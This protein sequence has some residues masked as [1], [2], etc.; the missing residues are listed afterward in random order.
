MVKQTN[1][2]NKDNNNNDDSDRIKGIQ[3]LKKKKQQR[4]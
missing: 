4:T 2:N 3:H 1:S